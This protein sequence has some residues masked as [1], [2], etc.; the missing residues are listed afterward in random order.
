MLCGLCCLRNDLVS[1]CG[2]AVH[3]F[4]KDT[5]FQLRN[6]WQPFKW[7][8]RE[9]HYFAN[10]TLLGMNLPQTCSFA[11]WCLK[12]LCLVIWLF[13]EHPLLVPVLTLSSYAWPGGVG[14]PPWNYELSLRLFLTTA[15]S[16]AA[17]RKAKV[18]MVFWWSGGIILGQRW[19]SWEVLKSPTAC[20]HYGGHSVL[21][22]WLIG[23]P[24]LVLE[25]SF[26]FLSCPSSPSDVSDVQKSL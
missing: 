13:V 3:E 10:V 7:R 2:C 20:S 26:L 5:V 19:V 1:C 22:T 9:G 8:E 17:F 11:E 23:F 6:D 18:I 16:C 4:S 21:R 24:L 15:G 14:S 12:A 25:V